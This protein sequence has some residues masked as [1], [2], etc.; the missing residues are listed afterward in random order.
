MEDQPSK[1]L[2]YLHRLMMMVVMNYDD[3]EEMKEH[4]EPLAGDVST[5]LERFLEE[6]K[7]ELTPQDM[8][9]AGRVLRSLGR[10]PSL[11]SPCSTHSFHRCNQTR[12]P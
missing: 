8:R 2:G 12:Q 11:L 10:L 6:K 9:N 7:D 3:D 1:R 5:Y 4:I